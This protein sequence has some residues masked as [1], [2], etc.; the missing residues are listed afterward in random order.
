MIWFGRLGSGQQAGKAKPVRRDGEK[1]AWGISLVVHGCILLLLMV[2]TLPLPTRKA[3]SLLS[4]TED[5]DAQRPLEQVHFSDDFRREIGSSR[6]AEP[7]ALLQAVEPHMAE[8][9]A[10]ADLAEV[11]IAVTARIPPVARVEIDVPLPGGAGVGVTGVVGAVDRLTQEILLSLEQRKTLVV[12]IFDQ[13]GS[14]R[15]QRAA[16]LQRFERIYAELGI[17]EEGGSNAFAR[18][19]GKPL[20]T[21]VMAFGGSFSYQT[22]EPTDELSVIQQAVASIATDPSGQERVFTA[23]HDAARRF[24]K[25]RTGATRRNVMIVVVTDEAGDDQEG[26]DQT[27]D[28]CRRYAM[29]VYVIGVPAPFGRRDAEIKYVDPDP[30]FDQ[31][32]QWVPVHQGPESLLPERLRLY[33]PGS[34]QR[35]PRVDSGFGPFSL[36]RLCVETGGIYFAVHANRAAGRTVSRRQTAALAAHFVAFFDREVMQA[37]RPDYVSAR[38]Y[39]AKLKENRAR[40][41]LVEAA[42]LSWVA[43]LERVRTT[44]PKRS[45]AE[46]AKLLTQAQQAAAKLEPKVR[47]I[48]DLLQL[49]RKDRSRLTS[50]RWQAGYD[51]AIGRA[52]AVKVRTEAYNAMLARAKRGMKFKDPNSDT[53]VLRPADAVSVG[54]LF[55]KQADQARGDLTRVV[56]DHAGTPWAMLAERQL[57]EPLGWQWT[58]RH[59][60]VADPPRQPS[61]TPPRPPQNERPRMLP[62]PKPRRKPPAL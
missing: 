39:L 2:L 29:P 10:P 19:G 61:A 48:Y 40:G 33:L 53:W 34:G 13:S 27:V 5:L 21:A 31:T 45:E 37:Y 59:T 36:T 22:R 47:R 3:I 28:L 57:A 4:K 54:S 12:W 7:I 26:L 62:R 9:I 20:L 11:H 56:Q 50:P 60:G 41:T 35:D 52:L 1:H 8:L 55:S 25:F 23:V 16:I 44:F 32:P 30:N 43:P 51:L 46:L 38:D 6:A 58:E 18:H 14:L 17:L 49:G 24:R 42:R 15:R